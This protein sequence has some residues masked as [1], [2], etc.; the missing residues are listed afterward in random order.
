MPLTELQIKNL[1]PGTKDRKISDGRGLYLL[2][3][4]SGG[5][6]W[7]FKY[8]FGGKEKLMSLGVYPDVSLAR[9]RDLREVARRHV[10]EGIDPCQLRKDEKLE[11]RAQATETFERV[12]ELWVAKHIE[13]WSVSHRRNI[14]G[15][16]KRDIFPKLGHRPVVD[17]SA[18]EL[19]AVLERI[20]DRGAVETARRVLANCQSIFDFARATGRA[21]ENPASSLKGAL[22][23]VSSRHLPAITDPS[24]LGKLLSAIHDYRG[25]EVVRVAL[26]L[27][28]LVFVRPGELRQARW[29]DIDFER[30]E[31]RF[32]AS[33]TKTELIVPLASQAI[34]LLDGYK[35]ERPTSE[36]VFPSL[37][38]KLRP[39]SNNAV[40]SALRN[41]GFPKEQVVGHGFRATARTLLAEVLGYPSEWIEHQLAHRVRDPLGRAYNRTQYLEQRRVMMQGWADYLDQLRLSEPAE[42]R[43]A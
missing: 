26:K 12:A 28:P 41:L 19:L 36:Y 40:L 35:P 38:S 18:Q 24:A 3:K 31:W 10:A 1:K 8:R 13:V 23:K 43:D 27:A 17:I 30:A 5:K 20:Q 22:K 6:W 33:K 37:R 15:R 9:A 39:M 11:R 29:A 7:R 2:L 21:N 25:T 16:L 42:P 4:S 14:E 34:A 32:I